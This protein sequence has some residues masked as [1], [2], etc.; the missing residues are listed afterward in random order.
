VQRSEFLFAIGREQESLD[1]I[2]ERPSQEVLRALQ[3]VH[4]VDVLDDRV[5]HRRLREVDD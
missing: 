5:F 3:A 1:R 4:A 2:L